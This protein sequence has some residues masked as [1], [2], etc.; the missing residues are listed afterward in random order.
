M[1]DTKLLNYL[2]GRRKLV[3][4]SQK[5]M[6]YLLG[7]H[8]A[9]SISRYERFKRVPTLETALRME[10]I[11]GVPVRELFAGLYARAS[12]ATAKRARQLLKQEQP[13]MAK[14]GWTPRCERFRAI[15]G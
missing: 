9:G 11:L 15:C 8:T 7:S 12:A 1:S 14:P 13:K 4:F 2:R 6:A 10:I 5:E 3:G